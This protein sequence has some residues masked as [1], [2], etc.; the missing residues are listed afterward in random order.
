MARL[1]GTDGVRGVANVPPMTAETALQIGRATAHVCRSHGTRR[2]RILIGKDTRMSGCL[3]E[4]AL[5]AGICSMGADTLLVGTMTTPGIAFLTQSLR[6]DAGLVISASHNPFQDNGI[7]IFS[8]DGYKLPDADED[9]IEGLMTSGD[10]NNVRP[11]ANEIGRAWRIENA[12]GRYIVFCKNAFPGDLNLEGLK[13]VLDCANGATYRVAPPVFSELGAN[14][15][16][17]HCEPDGSNINDNCG[18]QHTSSMVAKVKEVG[19]DI[20]LAFDGDGDRLIA[21]D[22]T[23]AELTGDHVL[24]ICGTMYKNLGLLENNLVIS[25]VMSNIGFH[26]ALNRLGIAHG[27]CKV[28]DRYVLEM[29]REKGAVIGGEPSGHMIFLRHHTTGDGIV[30]AMQLLAAMKRSG[31]PLSELAT[32]MQLSPQKTINVEVSRKPPLEDLAELQAAIR[33]AEAELNESGRV[34]IR[35]SG[36]QAMCRVMVE[37]PTDEIT[38]RLA[39]QLAEAVKKSL[40]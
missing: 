15:T 27:V 33:R 5:T 7:K 32:I 6:A 19:A 16:A 18:S 25:T 38:D 37:G 22:E 13:I 21:V 10:I 20:G 34:L 30:S 3:L 2:P 26:V 35:Y 23:G 29:M 8:R 39:H 11:T 24:A 40:N 36:T 1:F 12:D 4:S 28:G 17:I 14:A 9:E 31:K